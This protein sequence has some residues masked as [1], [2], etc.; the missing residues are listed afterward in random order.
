MQELK[1][2]RWYFHSQLKGC[3]FTGKYSG[4]DFGRWPDGPWNGSLED[5]D[6]TEARLD[7]CRFIGCDVSTLRFP[8]W[9]HFTLLDTYARH[10]ELSAIQWPGDVGCALSGF[11]RGPVNTVAITNS[12]TVLAKRYGVSEESIKAVVERL[13]GVIF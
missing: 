5:C 12:A 13:D 10:Q 1:N 7:A 3:R 6:F 4:N 9:P 11:D 8:R 2:F